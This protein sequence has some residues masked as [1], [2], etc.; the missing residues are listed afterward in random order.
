MTESQSVSMGTEWPVVVFNKLDVAES[1]R[2]GDA[3]TPFAV[4]I[5][6]TTQA[7]TNQRTERNA[8]RYPRFEYAAATQASA[9]DAL[10]RGWSSW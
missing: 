7:K 2:C 6:P 5:C 4:S 1:Q 9:G 8:A 10:G 3:L